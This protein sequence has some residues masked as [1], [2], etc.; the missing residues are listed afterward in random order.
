MLSGA[1]PPGRWTRP[2]SC[3]TAGRRRAGR[4]APFTGGLPGLLG[5]D[6]ARALEPIPQLARDDLALPALQ[7][8]AVDSL[9]AFDRERDE[10][11]IVARAERELRRL[12]DG[13]ARVRPAARPFPP[14][15]ELR[16][17]PY[18]HYRARVERV[19]DHIGRGDV[20]EVNYTQRLEGN[21]SSAL[22]LYARLRESAPRIVGEEHLSRERSA[23]GMVERDA[24]QHRDVRGFEVA[25]GE[26]PTCATTT[27][28]STQRSRPTS[29][30]IRNDRAEN[31][32]IVDLARNDLSACASRGRFASRRSASSSRIRPCISWSRR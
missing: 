29:R 24:A 13:L 31:V 27:P 20:Y 5:Y 14:G 12:R 15:D 22:D 18:A 19:L 4:R 16:G 10:L 23:R 28:L 6:L 30:R 8:A 32:M 9:Y 26:H 7:L 2:A 25:V 1:I 11:W 17:M 21:C 3:S